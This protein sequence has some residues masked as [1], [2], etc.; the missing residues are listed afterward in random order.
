M[1]E[2]LEIART[3]VARVAGQTI[4]ILRRDASVSGF[5]QSYDD[6]FSELRIRAGR[7]RCASG[8]LAFSALGRIDAVATNGAVAAAVKADI[9]SDLADRAGR[10]PAAVGATGDNSALEVAIL[11]PIKLT[12]SRSTC[13]QLGNAWLGLYRILL[14]AMDSVPVSTYLERR[15]VRD[16][17]VRDNPENPGVG[18]HF[19][20]ASL[21]DALSTLLDRGQALNCSDD[22]IAVRILEGFDRLRTNSATGTVFKAD[23][24]AIAQLFLTGI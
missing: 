13:A 9:V 17:D 19:V 7:S 11:A 2:L 8:N 1:T 6:A 23:Q 12:G 18:L 3:E 15:G 10:S 21:D 24:I 22:D 4:Q 5:G 20:S 14:N 16:S